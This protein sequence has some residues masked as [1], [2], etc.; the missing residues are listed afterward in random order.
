MTTTPRPRIAVV[1]TGGTIAGSSAAAHGQHYEA[2]VLS[3]DDLTAAAPGLTD[4]ADIVTTS[5]F[6]VDSIEMDLGRRL[7]LARRL[8]AILAGDD[9]QVG[10]VEGIVV[11]HGTDTMEESAYLLHLVLDTDVPV[12]LTGAMRP[13]DDPGADG[14]ANLLD[15]VRLAASP[16]ARGLGVLVVFGGR[17]HGARDVVKRAASTLDAFDS[18]HGPLG[19][20]VAGRVHVHAGSRRARG[21]FPTASLPEHLPRVE[22]LATHPE[23][24]PALASA[25]LQS[26][27][28]GIVHVGS[29]GGNVCEAGAAALDRAR[30]AGIAV[31]RTSRTG[32]GVVGR[33]DAVDDDAHDW[34][35]AGDLP[36][37]KARV[38]LALALTRTQQT[39]D[40]QHLFDTH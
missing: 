26:A 38:L 1:G 16:E 7:V 14:P 13:A 37:G 11:T 4:V 36:P 2:G 20:V 5:V 30:A 39:T 40:L 24:S 8:E 29:G 23:Q 9:A 17:V 28:A 18:L 31:V 15:A 19:E 34:I 22:F 10:P 35:A 32:A 27:P 21:T 33:G 6:S 12:V 25:V 3:V